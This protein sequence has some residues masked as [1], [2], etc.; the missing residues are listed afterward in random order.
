MHEKAFAETA[1][2]FLMKFDRN[3]D[4]PTEAEIIKVLGHTIRLKIICLLCS[5]QCNVK[6]IC[7]CLGFPQQTVS[8]HLAMLKYAGIVSGKKAGHEVYYSVVHP[9]AKKIMEIL[10]ESYIDLP[11][12]S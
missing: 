1:R 5:K 12:S 8:Q 2:M 7:E 9:L 4:Y 3:K 11:V 6:H 10:G